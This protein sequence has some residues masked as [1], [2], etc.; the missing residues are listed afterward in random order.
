ML[1][2]GWPIAKPRVRE[3][4]YINLKNRFLDPNTEIPTFESLISQGWR[5]VSFVFIPY[6][7]VVFVKDKAPAFLKLNEGRTKKEWDNPDTFFELDNQSFQRRTES[8]R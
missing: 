1:C 6:S 3:N 7:H 2:A 8:P 5:S 4:V